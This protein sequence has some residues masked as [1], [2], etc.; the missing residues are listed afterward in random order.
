MLTIEGK[1]AETHHQPQETSVC[2]SQLALSG[3]CDSDGAEC[4]LR[5][6]SGFGHAAPGETRKALPKN[7]LGQL[8]EGATRSARD[9]HR[10]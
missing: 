2:R 6:H 9:K 8:F 1:A 5:I 10:L 7:S 4:T 3:R